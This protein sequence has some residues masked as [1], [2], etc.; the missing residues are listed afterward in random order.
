M[1][2]CLNVKNMQIAEIHNKVIGLL[3]IIDSLSCNCNV[4]IDRCEN[5][6]AKDKA[7]SVM[8]GNT[9]DHIFQ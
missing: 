3:D 9:E 2:D 7:V 1:D 5:C 6:L 8:S 4:N